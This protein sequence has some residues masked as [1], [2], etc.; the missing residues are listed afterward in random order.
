MPRLTP[1]LAL[2]LALLAP[3]PA[4]A[5][6]FRVSEMPNGATLSCDGCHIFP[7]GPRN[8]LGAQVEA[9]M[10]PQGASGHTDWAAVF[11]L[12]ADGDGFSNGLELG[13]PEGTWRIGSPNPTF[14]SNPNDEFSTPEGLDPN[15]GEE[16]C[17]GTDDDC[18]GNIDEGFEG[19]NEPIDPDPSP[20]PSPGPSPD[21][22]PDQMNMDN[23]DL[24][25]GDEPPAPLRPPAP[26][27]E[28][29]QALPQRGTEGAEGWLL[30]VLG[31]GAC[32]RRRAP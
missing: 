2:A 5:R 22:S 4:Q 10:V 6:N 13:D 21:P 8:P 1:A 18:D 20:D 29:C 30:V 31:L 14:L 19:C 26:A 7:G 12:D 11:S 15:C 25:P 17:E 32:R 24:I 16:L 28:G 23:P 9:T 3:V 27:D